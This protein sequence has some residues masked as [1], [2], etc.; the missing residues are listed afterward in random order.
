MIKIRTRSQKY[1][2][3]DFVEVKE[4]ITKKRFSSTEYHVNLQTHFNIEVFMIYLLVKVVKMASR[5][6]AVHYMTKHQGG[7]ALG[8]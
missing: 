4:K 3:F 6:F 8:G 1:D 5:V 2:C 7:G